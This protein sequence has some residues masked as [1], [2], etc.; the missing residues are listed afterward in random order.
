[1]ETENT[2]TIDAQLAQANAEFD[3][4]LADEN[5]KKPASERIVAKPAKQIVRPKVQSKR[6][7]DVAHVHHDEFDYEIV[8]RDCKYVE[9]FVNDRKGFRINNVRYQGRVVVP[10]C[11]ANYLSKMENDN[12]AAE[13]GIFEN[14]GR[15]LNYGEIV[16]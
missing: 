11:V 12:H 8:E 16:G 14:R 2:Q 1:L 13:R 9:H 15:R 5:A 7:G 3:K 6:V 4:R 10:L